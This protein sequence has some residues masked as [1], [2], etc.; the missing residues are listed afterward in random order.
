[1]SY[2]V[3]AVRGLLWLLGTMVVLAFSLLPLASLLI[4]LPLVS[5][6]EA[7]LSDTVPTATSRLRRLARRAFGFVSGVVVLVVLVA[8]ATEIVSQLPLPKRGQLA[9]LA[10]KVLGFAPI[11]VLPDPPQPVEEGITPPGPVQLVQ[12]RRALQRTL[13]AGTADPVRLKEAKENLAKTQER[14][15]ALTATSVKMRAVLD[16]A[17]KWTLEPIHKL[18][19]PVLVQHWPFVFLVV[20]ATDLLLLLAIGKVPLAYNLRNLVVRWRISGLT[21]LAFTV[22]V[23]LL[24][25]LLA[26]V[27]GMYKLNDDTGIPGNVFVLSDGSTDELFSNLGYGDVDNTFRVEADLDPQGNPLKTPVRVQQGVPGPD[28][29]LRPLARGEAPPPGVQPVY[30]ASKEIYFVVN[31]PIPTKP[32]DTPRRRFLQV[33]AMENP[34]AAAAVHNISLYDG[35]KWFTRAGV[36][37]GA[38]GKEAIQCV[39]G[40]GAA[41]VLGAD[42]GKPRLEPGDTFVLGDLDWVVVGVMKAEGTTFGSEVWVQNIDLV[43]RTFG[44]KGNYTTLVL[45]VDADPADKDGAL[46]AA[47]AM[48]YHLQYRYPVQKLKAFAEPDYY[49]ELTKTNDQFLTWIV[50]VAVIMA[51]G[52]VFGVMNTMFAS[53]TARIREV[54][55]LRILGFKRWQILISFMLESLAIAFVGGLLGCALGYLANGFQATSTLSGGQGGGKSVSLRM[56]VDYQTVAAGML[57]TLMMGRIGGLV[58][59]LSAMRMKILDSLR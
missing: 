2:L 35:G 26:F 49:Q 22:V 5:P 39:L 45:R 13:A 27:N 1:M 28:G 6:N 50:M 42:V 8:A 58:P 14:I 21:A 11:D 29:S 20:Y 53:I 34:Y 33:R 17:W 32:G 56:L 25:A 31:Q 15:D 44:K 24:V 55:V 36:Q 4:A 19:P 54:G 37:P 9:P 47:K 46:A 52:G 51:I 57:F 12:K 40:E 16:P 7:V 38:N 3:R 30:L 18:L 41:G 10:E 48:A 23:G 43:T 59:A